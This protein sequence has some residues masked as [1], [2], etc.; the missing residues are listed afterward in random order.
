MA[1]GLNRL[2]LAPSESSPPA[3]TGLP[4][5]ELA[6]SSIAKPLTT[7]SPNTH[8]ESPV[9]TAT[10]LVRLQNEFNMRKSEL[11]LR[12]CSQD[13][14]RQVLQVYQ[15]L[16]AEVAA[17][18]LERHW[19]TPKALLLS[20]VAKEIERVSGRLVASLAH[21]DGVFYNT[22]EPTQQL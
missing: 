1:L 22:G 20:E 12:P 16:H 21:G 5:S 13:D 14:L 4:L 7:A 10:T 18:R 8:L 11:G 6:P 19:D 3:E 9:T 15:T 2:D 17:L